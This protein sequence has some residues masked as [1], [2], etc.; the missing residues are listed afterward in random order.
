MTETHAANDLS[1]VQ[2]SVPP[3]FRGEQEK[4]ASAFSQFSLQ[5]KK[6]Q[7]F[8]DIEKSVLFSSDDVSLGTP[9][10]HYHTLPPNFISSAA[11][12]LVASSGNC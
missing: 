1:P 9:T 5:K 8:S 4:K 6:H 11:N 12:R 2:A 7:V 3:M 10:Y